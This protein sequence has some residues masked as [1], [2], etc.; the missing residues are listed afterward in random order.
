MAG[1]HTGHPNPN[2]LVSAN[3]VSSASAVPLPRRQDLLRSS[4]CCPSAL[5]Q[6]TR[7]LIVNIPVIQVLMVFIQPSRLS[8]EQGLFSF[9]SWEMSYVLN[10][11]L[12]TLS[13]PAPLMSLRDTPGPCTLTHSMPQLS[14]H[15]SSGGKTPSPPRPPPGSVAA[16]QI[17]SLDWEGLRPAYMCL[18]P[19]GRG[20][21]V[22]SRIWSGRRTRTASV[23]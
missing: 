22:V 8:P 18:G 4:C 21:A 23:L 15:P 12:L 20:E 11:L 3:A 17:L 5:R 6:L 1:S 19:L 10:I 14:G 13:T 9:I 7:L 16:A 2:C